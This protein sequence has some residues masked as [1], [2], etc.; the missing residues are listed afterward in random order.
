M[1]M[2]TNNTMAIQA[3][4]KM[5]IDLFNQHKSNAHCLQVSLS[6]H[7]LNIQGMLN[8]GKDTLIIDYLLRV[9]NQSSIELPAD[10]EILFSIEDKDARIDFLSHFILGLSL[11]R[12]SN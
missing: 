3:G 4:K 11:G 7:I 9:A 10:F 6:T 8:R 12:N 2:N 5:K 1:E